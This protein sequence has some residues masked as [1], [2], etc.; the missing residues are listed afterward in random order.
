MEAAAVSSDAESAGELL[1]RAAALVPWT[2]YALAALA[3]AAALLY[4]FL[5]LHFLGD[6]LRGLR[7]GRVA[8]TF[9]PESQ[10]YHR[11]ASKCRSLHGRYL[12]T[13]WLASPHLQTLFLSISG[14]P[15][16]FTYRRQL[17]TVRDGG[18]IAL[19]WLLA[20]DLEAADA[21][22]CDESISKDD[23]TPL[24][25]VIPG[26]TS[27]SSAAYVKH[28]V[29]S[30]ASKG[31]N[32]VVSN[33][34]GLGGISITSD[35]F[36][37]AGWTED[38]REVVNFLHQEYPEAP[39][40]TVGTSIGA[41]IVVKYLGEEGESTPVVG[42]ASICS[43]WDLLVTNRFISRKLVQRCYDRALAIGLKG[44]A[45]LHQPVLA[46]LANWEAITSSSSIREFDRH[47]TCVVAKYE[48]VDTFYRKCSSANYIGNVS[49]PLLCIS[50]LDDP[51]CTREAIPWD[52]CRANK[53]VVLATTP[54]GGH[55]AFFEGLTARRLWWVRPVSEFLCALHDSSYM[56]RQKA[57]EHGLHSPLESSIDKS[58]YVNFM[59]DGM[60]AAVTNDGPDNNDSLHNQIVGEIE[61]SDGMVAIQQNECTGEI[62]NE[63]YSGMGDKK[64]SEENV[65]SVQGH[66]G[67]HRQ[68]EEPY[69]NNIGDAI[70]PVRR[71]INQL[72]RS[73]GK[74]VWLLAYIAVVTSWPLLGTLGFFLFRK[75]FS[76]SLLAKKLK[77]L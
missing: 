29:F 40:F 8:L 15:P 59:E 35:C 76:N 62:Q 6:L 7:G 49:V 42:A 33:H 5:E 69:A 28:L 39:L 34:R 41:N 14:R 61:L 74:S 65:T 57:Q 54:N 19:D 63:S 13:P 20:S 26:L 22:S 58:P 12:A 73:Q 24:L 47:A 72:T 66:E 44:Y 9:H 16:S 48:T 50:A 52:E 32:V 25:V 64:N 31:W 46:R 1:L 51:L 3:L 77:K 2:R 27:D 68:R 53:N 36:Y 10:V 4:R 30:M 67:N 21:D 55:L 60:V 38:M 37:N 43:P 75:R 45:K 71:S 18:T 56:H 23:L 11:V 17:Y 70:A